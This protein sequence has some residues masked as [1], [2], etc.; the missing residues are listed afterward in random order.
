MYCLLVCSPIDT[1]YLDEYDID[2][3]SARPSD[4]ISAVT[5]SHV[6]LGGEDEQSDE[7]SKHDAHV[8]DMTA[9]EPSFAVDYDAAAVASAD[10]VDSNYHLLD[11]ESAREHHQRAALSRAIHKATA[12]ID[13]QH[14]H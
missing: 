14:S 7:Q 1:S 11:E 4:G 2:G 8:V 13:E 3:K 12:D 5:V 10:D 6:K 9:R